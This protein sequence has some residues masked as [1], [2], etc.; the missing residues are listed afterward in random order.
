MFFCRLHIEVDGPVIS[1]DQGS[2]TSK[3]LG[4]TG[5]ND[6]GYPAQYLEK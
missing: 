6:T 3:A 2:C 4:I 5:V 1:A